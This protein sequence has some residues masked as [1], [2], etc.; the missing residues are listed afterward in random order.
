MDRALL[1]SIRLY[2]GRFHGRR[3]DGAREWPPAPARLFQALVAAANG[4]ASVSAGGEDALRW[5]ECA[6]NPVIAAPQCIGGQR[7]TMFVPNNDGDAV[8]AGKLPPGK[9]KTGKVVQPVIFDA[10]QPLLYA[11]TFSAGKGAE[12]YAD[13]VCAIAQKLYQFGRGVDMAW[14]EGEVLSS[15][16]ATARLDKYKGIIY[17]PAGV[18]GQETLIC[19][20]AGS[21]ESLRMR[22][23]SRPLY[24]VRIGK[25]SQATRRRFPG[26]AADAVSYRASLQ[27]YVYEL[28]RGHEDREFAVRELREAAIIT[29]HVRDSAAKLLLGTGSISGEG[30]ERHLVGRGATEKD[31]AGRV[32]IVPIPSVGHDHADMSIRRIAVYAPRSGPLN[33]EDLAWAFARVLWYDDEDGVVECELQTADDRTMV[34]RFERAGRRWRSVTPLALPRARRRRIDPARRIDEAK[35]GAERAAEEA[36]AAAAVRQALRHAGVRAVVEHV[37]VQREPFDRRGARA[38]DFAAGT[39]FPKTSL[40][41]ASIVFAEPADP[42]G[43]PLVLG[44]GRYLGLGLMLANDSPRDTA[45]FAVTGGLAEGARPAEVARAARR[46]MMSRAQL[47]VGAGK[48]LPTYISGHDEDGNPDGGGAHRHIA[49]V[50]DLPRRR[51]LFVPP[52]LLRRGGPPW[53]ETADDRR[54]RRVLA[55][56]LKGMDVLRA[57]AAGKLALAPTTLDT[58]SD[59]LFAPVRVWE[60]VTDYDVARHL[61]RASPEDALKAD[62]AAELLRCGWPRADTIE[63]LAARR[64]PRDGLSG[65]LRLTFRA[66]QPGP[67]MI[68][69]TAHKGGGLFAAA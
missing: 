50:A 10:S 6:G 55:N 60:S 51:I 32:H 26:I 64:G 37:H 5:L 47:V 23:R 24:T 40:W 21:Y 65:R 18:G 36:R 67:L 49:V 2:D 34:E 3:A 69:R 25:R 39:R 62:V 19:P 48:D 66:A 68:G 8:E 11:W 56:A 12:R 52:G 1:L 14:A 33:P 59:P 29:Q 54:V 20:R 17:Y 7:F 63:V 13:T 30:V 28:R 61:R 15:E 58:E 22:Y 41:H 9:I 27:R 45:V 53:R 57:G 16:E 35:D 42:G 31:K 38:E 4:G 43:R 44:D 46:A